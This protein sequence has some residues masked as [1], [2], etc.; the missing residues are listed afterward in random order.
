MNQQSDSS[1]ENSRTEG[2]DWIKAAMAE[3]QGALLRYAHHFVH[4]ID[5]AR[6]IVQDTFLKLCRQDQDEMRPKLV[7]WLF[8]VCRNRA[9]DIKRKESRMKPSPDYQLEERPDASPDAQG[10]LVKKEAAA[11]LLQHVALLPD[12]QQEILRLKFNGGLSY[13]QIAE[14]TGLTVTNV[15]VILHTAIGKLRKQMV[16]FN[17]A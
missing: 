9:I 11:G 4:D 13:R 1:A 16:D 10:Q 7:K 8:T 3:H 2:D 6:D 15:G 14:V 17:S 5:T 12:R